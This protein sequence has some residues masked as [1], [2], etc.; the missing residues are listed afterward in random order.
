MSLNKA[1]G[2][3]TK[4]CAWI[5]FVIWALLF[6]AYGMMIDFGNIDF[7]SYHNPWAVLSDWYSPWGAIKLRAINYLMSPDVYNVKVMLY[8]V[9]LYVCMIIVIASSVILYT[10]RYSGRR[11]LWFLLFLFLIPC[12]GFGFESDCSATADSTHI[13]LSQ[14]FLLL[15]IMY[16]CRVKRVRSRIILFLC[17]CLLFDTITWRVQSILILPI[18]LWGLCYTNTAVGL[19]NCGKRCLLIVLLC[20]VFVFSLSIFNYYILSARKSSSMTVMMVSDIYSMQSMLNR[21]H[22]INEPVRQKKWSIVLWASQVPGCG[23]PEHE[24]GQAYNYFLY[25]NDEALE[26]TQMM[27]D[28]LAYLERREQLMSAIKTLWFKMVFAHP[29]EFFAHRAVSLAQLLFERRGAAGVISGFHYFFSNVNVFHADVMLY[30]Y[31]SPLF[32]GSYES[33]GSEKAKKLEFLSIYST[34]IRD[35]S[36]AFLLYPLRVIAYFWVVVGA[37]LLFIKK[38]GEDGVELSFS[39]IC[40]MI[41]VV[42]MMSYLPFT[43]TPDYRYMVPVI[44]LIFLSFVFYVVRASSA[45]HCI[46]EK[47]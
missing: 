34:L 23:N 35:V 46:H 30:R 28:D 21:P 44:M 1:K 25:S 3:I 20:L 6:F 45:K 7:N 4:K 8:A 31:R 13:F 9:K 41:G 43:P 33:L 36:I 12:F 38:R 15:S 26:C 29:K 17:F 16:F 24:V 22:V 40:L 32:S 5:V 14:L 2:Y 27:P 18:I 37:Y 47:A 42:Y 11:S 10:L 39:R 19:K